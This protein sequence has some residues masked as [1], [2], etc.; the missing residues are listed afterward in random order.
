VLVVLE[1]AFLVPAQGNPE[2]L[3]CLLPKLAA[4]VER[5]QRQI[6]IHHGKNGKVFLLSPAFPIYFAMEHFDVFNG[7]ADG[8]CA[9][10]QLRLAMP[11]DSILVTG[12]KRDIALLKRVPAAAGD[13]VTVLDIS[14]DVNRAALLDLLDRGVSIHYFDHHGS[15]VVPEHAGL[16]AVIDTA[17]RT[18]TGIIVDRYLG[19]QQRIWAIVAAF[20]DNIQQEARKLAGS[21]ALEPHQI[22]T[23]Q[24]LGECLN[25]NG[26]GDS[27]DDLIVHPAALYAIVKRYPDPFVFIRDEA[28]FQRIR[29]ARNADLEMA[30]RV[31]PQIT[32]PGGAVVVLPDAAWSRRVRGTYGKILANDSP[33][34][35]HAVLTTNRHGGYTVS[36]RAPLVAMRGAHQLCSQFAGGGGR[37]AAAGIDHLPSDQLPMFIRAFDR[38]FA[39][40]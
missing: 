30:R 12:I 16:Q 2:L 18:C 35:A 27:E 22:D 10:H 20:G 23:L 26:Y 33:Q 24:E 14:M 4:A 17:S 6:I 40:Q 29:E 32:L 15:G 3:G 28:V 34:R 5:K 36:V 1:Y 9:L 13:S 19:G 7:D 38:A 8:I 11:L 39:G 21:L 25:Y 37:L 31:Q